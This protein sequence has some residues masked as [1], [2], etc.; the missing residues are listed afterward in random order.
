MV[1][2]HGLLSKIWEFQATVL[3]TIAVS[4]CVFLTDAATRLAHDVEHGAD[5]L[6]SSN[7]V[8]RTVIHRPQPNP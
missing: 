5:A 6:R 2:I 1:G 7:Q 4:A 3:L 8:E